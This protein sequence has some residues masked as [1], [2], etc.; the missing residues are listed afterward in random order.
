MNLSSL[1]IFAVGFTAQLLFAARMIVQW[2]KSEKAGKSLSPVIFWQ[3]SILGSLIFLLYGILRH[4]FAIVLG[5]ILVYFIYIRNLHLQ[6]QWRP[7]PFMFRLI[8]IIAPII[9]LVYLL[10]DNQGNLTSLLKNDEIPLPL[11][12]WG[13][14]GQVIFTLRFY[15]QWFDSEAKNE[16][17]LTKRFWFVSI[18]GSFMIII[19][20]AFRFDPVLFLGQLSGLVIYLRNLMLGKVHIGK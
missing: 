4:D 1:W 13:S 2:V 17:V 5:Q 3:L 7:I 15:V 12:I 10:S 11:K 6:E 20:A 8:V 16:S 14:V 18:L 19:Y 9:T